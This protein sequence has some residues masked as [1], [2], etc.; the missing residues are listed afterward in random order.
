MAAN[1][2]FRI[3][4]VEINPDELR[5]DGFDPYKAKHKFVVECID[6]N[7][8]LYVARAISHFQVADKFQLNEERLVGGGSCYINGNGQLVLNDYSGSYEAIPQNVAQSFAEL[9]VPELQKQGI[10]TT[11]VVVDP[12]LS[13]LNKFWKDR[14]P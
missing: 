1:L 14:S 11:G 6:R 7:V 12:Q 3:G 9:L 2:E 13:R 4:G 5:F 10:Q 8:A